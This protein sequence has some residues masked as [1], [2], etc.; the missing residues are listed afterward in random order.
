ML[1][2]LHILFWFISCFW[3]L[4]FFFWRWTLKWILQHTTQMP[5]LESKH[6]FPS[7]FGS[8]GCWWLIVE[9]LSETKG[10]VSL[11]FIPPPW[12][13]LES[14]DWSMRDTEG[15]PLALIQDVPKRPSSFRVTHGN[16]SGIWG[17]YHLTLGRT[18]LWRRG[19]SLF[20]LFWRYRDEMERSKE[21]K[22]WSETKQLFQLVKD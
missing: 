18:V 1:L 11:K 8:V 17:T 22:I 10:G 6:W 3:G 19:L 13:Q 2:G 20:F 12:E 7:G 9:S 14:K 16:S 15:W 5:C 21:E 4:A